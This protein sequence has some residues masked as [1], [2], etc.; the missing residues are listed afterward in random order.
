MY[1]HAIEDRPGRDSSPEPDVTIV[2][3]AAA[4][5]TALVRCLAA[6]EPQRD[7]AEVVVLEAQPGSE[8]VH[9]RF[10]W[11][12]FHLRSGALVPE[13]WRDGIARAR[14]R[15]VALTIAQMIPAPDWVDAIIRAH[16]D[17]DAVG[18]AIDPGEGLRAADWA[19]Y[20][21]RYSRDM[22]PFAPNDHEELASDNASYRRAL[23]LEE[24]E[25]LR[26]GFWEP[27]IHPA[28]RRRGAR[29]WHTPAL[30]V[31]MGR[32]SGF[33]AFA[34]QRS[35]HGHLYAY[36]R[37]PEF[38]RARH[39]LG[40]AASPAVPF[41]MTARVLRRVFAKRRFRARA[42]A[43]LPLVFVLYAVWAIAEARGHFELLVRVR[44]PCG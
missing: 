42:I 35:K 28:L 7:R 20:F 27:V 4:S 10:P 23:L 11:A 25:Y 18:G 39:A 17:H 9:N 3:G 44:Q 5:E 21:C 33:S 1:A 31:F 13:L 22:A 6:L 40:V 34:R 14:G 16:Q 8:A 26:D 19:E 38:T 43:V 30:L 24:W 29:L 37:G 32:S 41:L 12:E 36:Q 2:V 15:I